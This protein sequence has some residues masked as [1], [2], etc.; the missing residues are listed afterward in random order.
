MYPD[1][2]NGRQTINEIIIARCNLHT[3]TPLAFNATAFD[4]IKVIKFVN[5]TS[6]AFDY[7]L[8]H[9]QLL[10]ELSFERIEFHRLTNAFLRHLRD[11]V[12]VFYLSYMPDNVDFETFFNGTRLQ[13][14]N[15]FQIVGIG[16][17]AARQ[18]S[19]TSLP[20]MPKVYG[21][22]L[23]Y[24]GIERIH[25]SA[26]QFF[27]TS[28]VHL[29]LNFN[30]LKTLSMQ[31]FVTFLENR[32]ST[33]K[34]LQYFNN[35]LVCNCDL[36]ELENFVY[37]NLHIPLSF[38]AQCTA[39][40]PA[41][42]CSN[43]EYISKEKFRVVDHDD[44]SKQI[45]YTKFD[46]GLTDGNLS[47]RTEYTLMYRVLILN[48]RGTQFQRNAKCPT[49]GWIRDSMVCFNL[50]GTKHTISI[51][52]F[53]QRSSL[54][55]IGVILTMANRR[56]W[57]LHL[58]TYRDAGHIDSYERYFVAGAVVCGCFGGLLAAIV[59]CVW[60]SKCQKSMAEQRYC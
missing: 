9:H 8:T 17:T 37:L 35:P 2:Y 46:I 31:S 25:F 14:C 23:N 44:Y 41:I 58:R 36:Y 40:D 6:L 51:K 11:I 43:I 29:N 53:L 10:K 33:R 7:Q 59:Y 15:Y 18:L 34:Y 49:P 30:R 55:T 20:R 54:T 60:E 48:H 1:W 28:L 38:M 39:P 47:A 32:R 24:C 22:I 4:F 5:I 50:R 56:M 3:V 12:H 16:E 45:G 27:G 26:F 19:W 52:D 13:R 42:K 57:P 21:I